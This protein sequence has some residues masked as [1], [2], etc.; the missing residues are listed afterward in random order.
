MRIAGP[1]QQMVARKTLANRD[2]E[3]NLGGVVSTL[4]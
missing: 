1:H 4:F 2:G 3:K